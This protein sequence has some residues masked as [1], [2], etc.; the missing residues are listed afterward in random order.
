MFGSCSFHKSTTFLDLLQS[1]DFFSLFDFPPSGLLLSILLR[2]YFLIRTRG[3]LDVFLLTFYAFLFFS[4]LLLLLPPSLLSFLPPGK[5]LPL[6]HAS[7]LGGGGSDYRWRLSG[8]VAVEEEKEEVKKGIRFH[9]S[10]G[11]PQSASL[12]LSLPPPSTFSSP[13]AAWRQSG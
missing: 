11:S 9:V 4:S 13:L 7:R 12:L 3:K 10:S 1:H 8:E 2:L 6:P 5:D